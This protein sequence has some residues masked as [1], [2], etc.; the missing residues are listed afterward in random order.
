MR[1]IRGHS[2]QINPQALVGM[3]IVAAATAVNCHLTLIM[4]S[5]R[6]MLE[7]P[8]QAYLRRFCGAAAHQL[9]FWSDS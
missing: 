1:K 4:L 3:M 6:R 7:G 5:F 9:R 2:A 8:A